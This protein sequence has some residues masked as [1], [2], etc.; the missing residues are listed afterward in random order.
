LA[1]RL[2]KEPLT[3]KLKEHF[4]RWSFLCATGDYAAEAG[5]SLF[6]LLTLFLQILSAQVVLR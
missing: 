6:K 3:Q 4:S 5:R 2:T 1:R